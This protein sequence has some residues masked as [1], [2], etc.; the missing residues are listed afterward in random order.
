[1]KNLEEILAS[2]SIL[3]KDAIK[4]INSD[5]IQKTLIIGQKNVWLVT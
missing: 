2:L 4:R 3:I 1:M 5:G